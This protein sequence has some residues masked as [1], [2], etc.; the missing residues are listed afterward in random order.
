[1]SRILEAMPLVAVLFIYTILAIGIA[2][3]ALRWRRSV[4]ETRTQERLLDYLER[5]AD[6]RGGG[7]IDL[8]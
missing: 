3:K 4:K 6:K 5:N 1:M 8:H 2:G 7:E